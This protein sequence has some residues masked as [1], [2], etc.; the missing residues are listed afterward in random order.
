MKVLIVEDEQ[1]IAQNIQKFLKLH[2]IYSA[3]AE[4]VDEGSFLAETES[5]SALILDWGL[6]DGTGLELCLTLRQKGI[7]T[8]IIFLT[9]KGELEHKVAGLNS[10]ADDYLTKPFS[11]EELLA[12]IKAVVRR[13]ETNEASPIWTIG[14]IVIDSNKCEVT[15]HGK[16]L[17]L[18]PKEYSL[19]EFLARNKGK[20]VNRMV[21]MEH[22]WGED[23][24]PLSNTVD[25]HIRY[26]R[27]KLGDKKNKLITTIKG[28]G[29]MLCD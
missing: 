17:E 18:S 20:V 16:K 26:L 8:P 12:R 21:I 9:A 11:L 15:Y 25:V 5:Y 2:Q 1:Q 3:V 7:N 4:T 27:M 6:P 24:D 22:V 29:Y 14:E 28:K 10:G 19:L 23:I 13:K